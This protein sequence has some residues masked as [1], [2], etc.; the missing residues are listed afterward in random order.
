MTTGTINKLLLLLW[1]PVFFYACRKD[2][3]IDTTTTTEPYSQPIRPASFPQAVY[4]FSSNTYSKQGFLL[5]RKLFYDPILSINNTVSCGSCHKQAYAFSD[6]GLAFSKG[7]NGQTGKRNSPA[8]FNMAWNKSFMWDGG[9]NHLEIMPFS[10]INNPLEMGEDLTHLI[11]KLND[12]PEYARLFKQVFNKDQIDDQQ[13]FYALAQFLGNIVSANSRYD[14]YLQGVGNFTS[15]EQD[16]YA[17]FK[18]NCSSCH[19]EPLF[20]NYTYQNNGIDSTFDD[21]GR[22][23]I[24]RDSTDLGKFKVPTLRNIALTYPYMHDGRFSSLEEVISHYADHVLQSNT[25]S[26]AL[27]K[28]GTPGLHLSAGEQQALVE[29]LQTLTDEQLLTDEALHQ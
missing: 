25:L 22:F 24:T 18:A 3:D 15:R 8:I 14:Q 29:F 23:R 7:I 27:V 17:V 26:P 6:A 11:K 12:N 2:K 9:V 19:T 21:A 1:V 20:T 10:P 5:G 28:N 4:Q 13:L 16:G